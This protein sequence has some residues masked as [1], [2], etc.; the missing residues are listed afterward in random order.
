M[1]ANCYIDDK[2]CEFAEP[3]GDDDVE[4]VAVFIE[5]CRLYQERIE[6]QQ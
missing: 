3:N 5:D 1:M 2:P 4:C 6:H